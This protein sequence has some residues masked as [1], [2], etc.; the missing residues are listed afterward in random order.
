VGNRPIAPSTAKINWNTIR[1]DSTPL[2]IYL[3]DYTGQR[4]GVDPNSPDPV[5]QAKGTLYRLILPS[6]EVRINHADEDGLLVE[7]GVPPVGRMTIQWGEPEGEVP[8]LEDGLDDDW[9][10]YFLYEQEFSVPEMAKDQ[11]GM[12]DQR[13]ANLGY[14]DADDPRA[15]FANDYGSSDD[16]TIADVHDEGTPRPT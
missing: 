9:E 1:V 14:G 12:V 4:M 3:L 7:Y 10:A 13:L 16:D 5:R 2:Q 6:G 15:A 8:P 11:Q